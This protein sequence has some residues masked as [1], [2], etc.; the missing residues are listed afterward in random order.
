VRKQWRNGV[1]DQGPHRTG[2]AFSSVQGL[3]ADLAQDLVQTRVSVNQRKLRGA[4]R[5]DDFVNPA[6]E[7]D[8]SPE[9]A[10]VLLDISASAGIERFAPEERT[11]PALQIAEA[12]STAVFSVP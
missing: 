6:A 4:G 7:G 12:A 2:L 9:N 1:L 8:F 5:K 3:F 11:S 10:S